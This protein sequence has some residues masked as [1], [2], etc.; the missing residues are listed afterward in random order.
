MGYICRIR[1]DLSWNHFSKVTEGRLSESAL[2]GSLVDY[3]KLIAFLEKENP[4]AE[5]MLH[6]KQAYHSY[7]KT[8]E[9][10]LTYQVFTSGWL[11]VDGAM[12]MRPENTL[13]TDYR[14]YLI[15][16]TER[17]LRELLL[18]FPRRCVGMFGIKE[19]WIEKRIQDI[20]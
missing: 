18:A 19:K 9:W 7:T 15:A 20:L 3:D 2:I 6:F 12:L 10:Q 8:G 14:V 16:T 1:C 4:N 13:D 17:S 5:E 11:K